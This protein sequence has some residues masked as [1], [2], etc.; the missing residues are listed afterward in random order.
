MNELIK[1]NYES[2]QPTVSARD[3]HERFNVETPYKKWID[4]MIEYGFVEEKDFWTKMSKSTGGRPSTDY[5]IT[6][7]MAKEIAML[8]RSPEGKQIR[9]YLINLESA[10]NTPEL[11]MA[12]ALKLADATITDLKGEVANKDNRIAEMRPKEIFADA[13][14]A[15]ESS[16][17]IGDLAKTL[18]QND[19]DI[20]R[21][22]LFET[23]RGEGYLIKK[24]TDRN[25]PT[26][27]AMDKGLFEVKLGSYIDGNG[28][29]IV[30]KTT[31]VTGK[32]LQYFINKFLDVA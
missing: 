13:V 20:G 8:Q 17:A 16:I 19:V 12:R 7:N 24:G 10:W 28:A 1:V 30:T 2:E 15:S 5:D 25:S 18:K 29:S 26:Q 27:K 32:G 22:R 14:S 21:N 6:V 11:V 31:K 9:V 3:L 23:L 4:R